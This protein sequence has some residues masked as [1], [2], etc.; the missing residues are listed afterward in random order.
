MIP[1]S[2]EVFFAT[3]TEYNL[4]VWPAQLVALIFGAAAALFALKAP[5]RAGRWAAALLVVAWG[6]SGL[7]YHLGE[8]AGIDF[9]AYGFGAAFVLQAA[10]TAWSGVIRGQLELE[11][12]RG[13]ANWLGVGLTGLG[14]AVHPLL[15]LALGRD[16]SETSWFGTS[17]GPT[18]LF[19]LGVLLMCR[20]RSPLYLWP[21]PL[22]WCAIAGAV[23]LELGI[24]ED[25]T[26]V[27]AGVAAVLAP[28]VLHV[29]ARS[30]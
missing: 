24:V 22:L 30:G 19:T 18:V 20:S 11:A 15:A 1:Y 10:L 28:L 7:V 9:W 2:A 17:P 4:S 8:F 5:A 6:W 12:E 16:G 27:A 13:P 3:L 26:L 25:L 23:A 21:I 29:R 14:L